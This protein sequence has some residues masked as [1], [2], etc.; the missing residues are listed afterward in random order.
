MVLGI[1]LGGFV[2]GIV[3]HQI[4][5]W[6]HMVCRTETCQPRSIEELKLQVTEDGYFHLAMGIITVI[7]VVLLFRAAKG[8][9]ISGWRV[10]GAALAGWGTFNFV[11][12]IVN[13]HLLDLHHVLPGRPQELVFDLLFL[14]SGVALFF[15]GRVMVMAGGS[16][17]DLRNRP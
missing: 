12:G 15:V 3:L 6:H 5:G 4:L 8:T 14:F 2:D 1:G 16:K 11:E 7:G 17:A 13:H 9:D 10:F